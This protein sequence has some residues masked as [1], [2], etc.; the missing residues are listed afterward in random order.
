MQ[1][2]LHILGT[3]S[4]LPMK[5]RNPS[6]HLLTACERSFLI[7][8]GEGT[9]MQL[10]KFD[11]KSSKIEKIFISH[12]HG[13]HYFGLIGLISSFHLYRRK[14]PLQIYAPPL[15]KEIIELQLNASHTKLLFDLVFIE[16]QNN[17]A[18]IIFEDNQFLIKTF[19]LKHRIQTQA[20]LFIQKQGLRKLKPEFVEIHNILH[21]QFNSIKNGDDFIDSQGNVFKNEE[22]TVDPNPPKSYAYCSDT[23]YDESIIE[24]VQNVD[25]IYH[26]ATFAEDNALFASEKFHST[27]K[28]AAKIATLADAKKL[29]I[30]HFSTRYS[31]VEILLNEAKEIFPNTVL[32][33][34]GLK[35]EI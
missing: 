15:L 19:P 20:F 34:E 23:I 13:D 29:V 5:Y 31:N 7:D 28:Q 30:G 1:L 17:F 24:Y 16:I 2:T 32:A 6:A 21:H 9:Q 12:L 26:E 4:A 33:K 3:N 11:L 35:I 27:A 22:I 25:V 8:C 18:G 14:S 10:Q